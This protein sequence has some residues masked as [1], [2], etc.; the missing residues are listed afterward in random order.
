MKYLGSKSRIAKY[1][2][3][4]LQSCIDDNSVEYYIEPFVG[5][6]GNIIDKVACEHRIG[7]D[8]NEYLIALLEHVANGG[9]LLD[10]VSKDYYDDIK[11]TYRQGKHPA[12]LVG[13][14]GFLASFNGRWFDGGYAAPGYE[15][16]K[17]GLIY[18]DYYQESKANLLRQAP[19]LKDVELICQDY[20]LTAIDSEIVVYCDPPYQNTKTY[21]VSKDFDYVEFWNTMRKWSKIA[22]VFV[23]EQ[24]APDDFVSIWHKE[25]FRSMRVTDKFKA[26]ENLYVCADSKALLW[27][28]RNSLFKTIFY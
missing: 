1:I 12:W 24:S 20:S 11:H 8:K 4:I 5:G 13:N 22:Y 10:T 9:E 15:K 27:A 7:S 23:S 6:G 17:A 3:P 19:L 28:K 14:V 21:K 25:T 2:V 26:T 18:R 16:T